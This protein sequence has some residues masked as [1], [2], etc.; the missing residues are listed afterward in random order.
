[1]L[2]NPCSASCRCGCTHSPLACYCKI[3]AG[4]CRLSQCRPWTKVWRG[5]I[6]IQCRAQ[7]CRLSPNH[8]HLDGEMRHSSSNIAG[9]SIFQDGK[10]KP[11][12]YRI[13]NIVS[14]TYVD[15]KDD[16]HELCGRPSTVLESGRGE[17]SLLQ[18]CWMPTCLTTNSGRSNPSAQ[19]IQSGRLVS[20]SYLLVTSLLNDN[21]TGR[22]CRLQKARSIL[23]Y[24]RWKVSHLSLRISRSMEYQTC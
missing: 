4:S 2:E 13:R 24:A 3:R 10:L 21:D 9:S 6:Y 7:C 22:T 16:V 11:G 12:I 15:I 17:V 23:H 8:H 18:L 5:R 1:M 20:P 19:G 14:Q